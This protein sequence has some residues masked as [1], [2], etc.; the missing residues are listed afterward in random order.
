VEEVREMDPVDELALRKW[1]IITFALAALVLGLA[2]LLTIMYMNPPGG[3]G[4]APTR[5][6]QVIDPEDLPKFA[7]TN[8]AFVAVAQVVGPAVVRVQTVTKVT[9]SAFP[10]FDFDFGPH[11]FFGED[12]FEFFFGPRGGEEREF[13][14]EGNGSGVIV[15]GEGYILTNN[16]VVEGAEEIRVALTDGRELDAEIIGTD[17]STDLAVIKVEAG[18]LPVAPLGNS[19]DLQVGDW[20]VALGSPFGLENTVTAG[21]VSATGR[22]NMRLADY[23][24]FIQT[25]AAI[26]PGNSGGALSNLAGEVV[27]I[28]T[29]IASRTG[30]YMGVGFAIP[31]NL[32]RDVMGQLIETGAVT[33]GW[34][35]VSIQDVTPELRESFD[36]APDVE[37]A[38][39]AEV[40][41]DT[42]A[43][44]A[45]IEVG[46]VIT[47][48]DGDKIGDANELRNRVAAVRPGAKVHLELLREGEEMKLTLEMGERPAE[49]TPTRIV[50]G[51]RGTRGEKKTA[52]GV[53]VGSLTPEVKSE[54]DYDGETGVAVLDV[55]RYSAASRAGV[56][57]GMVIVEVN[58]EAVD[59]PGE[60]VELAEGTDGPVLLYVWS[61]GRRSF[62]ALPPE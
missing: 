35:G 16:H 13:Y 12:P 46:D 42:P 1:K 55:E 27:G 60:F 54:L 21:I 45:G 28:N 6:V 57:P 51:D 38:L 10:G 15:S 34:L 33:R 56:A 53:T 32:A 26:N 29:A 18:G 59:D 31:I 8:K 62:I 58:R 52:R 14:T 37:G 9:G 48:L 30:G 24:D 25:D 61:A 41:E 36:L 5:P 4:S 7:D 40:L 39:V 3:D 49:L 19:D 22:T 44:E 23:E 43:E 2:V 50:P 11:D 47:G 20:V 17:P